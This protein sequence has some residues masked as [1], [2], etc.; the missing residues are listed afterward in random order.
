MPEERVTQV[1]GV[2]LALAN[3][4]GLLKPGMAADAWILWQAEAD[5]PERLVLPR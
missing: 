3:P 2:T 5:W 1:F 4:D